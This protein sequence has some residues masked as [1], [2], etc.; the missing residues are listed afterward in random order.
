MCGIVLRILVLA[1]ASKCL[2]S[3]LFNMWGGVWMQC[4]SAL[5]SILDFNRSITTVTVC[6]YA[7]CFSD[8]NLCIEATSLQ[9]QTIEQA[10]HELSI[11]RT[12][13]GSFQ[14]STSNSVA[15][16]RYVPPQPLPDQTENSRDSDGLDDAL[17][18]LLDTFSRRKHVR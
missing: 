14:S 9:W 2:L 18:N 7:T 12:T 8:H 5:L 13:M 6:G 15:I 16:V 17:M 1:L 4:L 11:T 3:F 10:L